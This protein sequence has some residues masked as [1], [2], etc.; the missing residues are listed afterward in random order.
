MNMSHAHQWTQRLGYV[1]YAP[2]VSLD[3]LTHIMELFDP[4]ESEQAF[5]LVLSTLDV[6]ALGVIAQECSPKQME[7]FF[8]RAMTEYNSD[9]L[10]LY[11]EELTPEL[12]LAVQQAV[13]RQL[14]AIHSS[15]HI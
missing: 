4:D 1:Y 3:V 6:T 5:E 15:L 9:S 11:L 7:E 12:P 13:E 10:R 8:F 2:Y 14:L